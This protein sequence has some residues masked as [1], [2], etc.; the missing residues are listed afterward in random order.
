M[1]YKV[2][3]SSNLWG[4][5]KLISEADKRTVLWENSLQ[6]IDQLSHIR[7]DKRISVVYN[8]SYESIK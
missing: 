4:G 6:Y 3:I 1:A 2:E 8:D 5:Y 7:C